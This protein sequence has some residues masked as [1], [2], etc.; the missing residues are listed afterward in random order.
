MEHLTD[1]VAW[2][3]LVIGALV[4]VGAKPL[5]KAMGGGTYKDTTLY[6]LKTIA[7][8]CVVVGAALIFISGGMIFG[9]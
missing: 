3:F 7:L 9:K 2:A 8:L 5:L 4:A 1:I 6:A